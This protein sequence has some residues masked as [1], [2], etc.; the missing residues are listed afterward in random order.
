M[1]T[2]KSIII[3]S[4]VVALFAAAGARAQILTTPVQWSTT[5]GG[6]GV[7][8]TLCGFSGGDYTWAG[9]LTEAQT[10]SIT[11]DGSTLFGYLAPVASVDEATFLQNNLI[12]TQDGGDWYMV[13]MGNYV[14]NGIMY[15]GSQVLSDTS[16]ITWS[17]NYNSSPYLPADTIGLPGNYGLGI[18]GAGYGPPTYWQLEDPSF[19]G[20]GQYIVAFGEP[21]PA[22]E[23]ST[24]TLAA[25][26]IG[27]SLLFL[28]RKKT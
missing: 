5:D 28:R 14:N 18:S 12:Q 17:G 25:P 7:Y 26:G 19:T 6:N 13:W 15:A 24:L 4:V 1:R 23:P 11:V 2:S 10:Y 20:F 27:F 21:S 9:A 16:W 22:P 8:Y 3:A